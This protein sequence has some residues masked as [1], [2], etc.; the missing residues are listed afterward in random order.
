MDYYASS[1][2]GQ[3]VMFVSPTLTQGVHTLKLRVTGSK[4]LASSNTYITV[5]R[6]DVN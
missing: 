3:Q 4:N 1:R 6:A 2:T 5:D